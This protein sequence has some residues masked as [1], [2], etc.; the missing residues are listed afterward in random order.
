V[1][2][3]LQARG[4]TRRYGSFTAVDD[5]DLDVTE[6]SI[7]S[8]IGPNGAGKTT[9]FRLL[10]GIARPTAGRLVFAGTDVTGAPPHVMARRGLA[11]SF[12]LTAIFPRLTLLESVQAAIVAR[13]R[14]GFDLFHHARRT[15]Q[16]EAS[17]VLARVGL[18]ELEHREARTLSHGDQR[19]LD[20]A[21]ALAVRPRLLLLDE[22]TA[23]M[24][25]VET[26]RTVEMI[27]Q[28]A[29]ADGLTVL[30]SEHDMDMVFGISETITVLHQGR[31]IANGP[32]AQVRADRDV[33]AI[34]LGESAE[35]APSPAVF[36]AGTRLP[37]G[38][39]STSGE[40]RA[41]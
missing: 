23:G 15:D 39:P 33:M 30:F 8:V 26:R 34:Y 12:Q 9:L 2:G 11:Q 4:L 32:A 29:R 6:G 38:S 37:I 20:I 18:A 5:V 13:R 24:S 28:L 17:E 14:H 7:H 31:V 36:P 21:L 40:R 3:L 27:S 16:W 35:A 22:P 25:A 1:T 19:A 10:T 41:D